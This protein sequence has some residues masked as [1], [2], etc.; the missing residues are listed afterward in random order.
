MSAFSWFC[1]TIVGALVFVGGRVGWL[2]QLISYAVFGLLISGSLLMQE[3]VQAIYQESGVPEPIAGLTALI[4]LLVFSGLLVIP[5]LRI[6]RR[7]YV[8]SEETETMK[9]F[10]GGLLGLILGLVVCYFSGQSLLKYEII[11]EFSESYGS[12]TIRIVRAISEDSQD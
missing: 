6:H 2:T 3:A 4:T 9:R 1:L 12:M 7:F 8:R 10:G 5:A 11:D